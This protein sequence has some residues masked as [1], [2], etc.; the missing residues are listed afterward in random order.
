MG[1]WRAKDNKVRNV[2]INHFR[3]EIKIS[4]QNDFTYKSL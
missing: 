4:K 2:A 3:K 1:Y